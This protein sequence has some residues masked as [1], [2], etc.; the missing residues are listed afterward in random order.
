[1]YIPCFAWVS[2]GWILTIGVGKE[3]SDAGTKDGLQDKLGEAYEV[4]DEPEE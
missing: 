4:G 2:I 3:V 1:M